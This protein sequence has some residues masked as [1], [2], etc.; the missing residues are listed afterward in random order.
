MST[1]PITVAELLAYEA[2]PPGTDAPPAGDTYVV[3]DTAANIESLTPDQVTAAAAPFGI[4]VSAIQS[5]DTTIILNE[6]Q[7]QAINNA[8]LSISAPAGKQVI[9]DYTVAEA[10]PLEA[11][12]PV[13][14]PAIA[15]AAV[16]DAAANVSTLTPDQISAPPSIGVSEIVAKGASLVLSTAQVDALANI[17]SRLMLPCPPAIMWLLRTASPTSRLCPHLIS[18][19]ETESAEARIGLTVAETLSLEGPPAAAAPAAAPPIVWDTAANIEGL[20]A[21]QISAL[22]SIGIT[23]IGASDGSLVLNV[24]QVEAIDNASLPI[25]GGNVTIADTAANISSLPSADV[26][27][28]KELSGENNIGITVEYT[29]AQALALAAS[30][31]GALPSGETA[32]VLDTAA[33]L[34]T[35]TANQITAL[36]SIGVTSIAA[37][38]TPA[39]LSADIM[40]DLGSASIDVLAPPTDPGQNDG[41]TVISGPPGDG[42]TFD[43]TWDPSVASAPAGF[44][45]D[46][47]EVFQ[48][49][50][51]T[52]VDPT[53]LYYHVGWGEVNNTLLN[54]GLGASFQSG[55][56]PI[57]YNRFS[58]R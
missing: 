6:A 36:A 39:V 2:N 57:S 3:Q 49:Y 42:M 45:T 18:A 47:E 10:V 38:D 41:T 26:T 56:Y 53:T 37:T 51:D 30:P 24:A 13:S 7:A 34:E 5:T 20:S 1:I 55:V 16:D 27:E 33:N 40:N 9:V 52:F 43:I 23:A 22:S 19:L 32:I 48:F 29:L 12:P 11:P 31:H 25:L 28:L 35:L 21:D 58:Q 8:S 17:T 15:N 54:S 50:A 14:L 44:K 4:G 46:V